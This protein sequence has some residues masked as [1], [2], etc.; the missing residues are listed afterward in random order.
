MASCVGMF[1]PVAIFTIHVARGR[2]GFLH[3]LNHKMECNDFSSGCLAF[4]IRISDDQ[5]KAWIILAH[6]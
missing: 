6:N 3:F 1:Y 2:W 5:E 4:R